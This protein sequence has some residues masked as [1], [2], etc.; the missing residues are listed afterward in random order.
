MITL[1]L[2]LSGRTFAAFD[3]LQL[4]QQGSLK[5]ETAYRI[6]GPSVFTKIKNQ[7]LLSESIKLLEKLNFKIMGRFYYDLVYPLAHNFSKNVGSDQKTEIE[8]RDTYFDYSD[9]PFDIRLGKQQIVW[10]E[11]VGLFFADVVNAKDLREFILPEFDLIRIP[12]WGID[13]EY[14]KKNFHTEFIWLPIVAFNKLG[15]RGAEFEFP[16]PVPEGTSFTTQDPPKSKNSF[17]NSEAGAR[18]SYLAHGWD[19]STFYLYSW[20]K[21]PIYYRAIASGVYNFK[22]LHK[23]LHITGLTLAK[24]I[25]K[26]VYKSEVVFTPGGY[27]SIF[28]DTDSDGIARKDFLDYLLGIDFTLFD[29]IDNTIQFMQRVI[30]DYDNHLVNENRVRNS[31]SYRINRGFWDNKL[32]AEFLVI[33]SLMEKDFLYRPKATYTFKNNWKVRVGM[34]IFN[35]KPAGVFGKF[36]KKSRV[37]SELT[38]SF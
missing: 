36:R 1:C 34:D 38:Y 14:T 6:S 23:R 31:I 5:N 20:D 12:Q 32:E 26:I 7:L 10:G 16:Y 22:P 28:D 2:Y 19:I 3:T 37:Y 13:A 15:V 27:F 9:G 30:F 29:K 24:E 18:F 33:A 35:G 4:K 21:F 17:N 11:A 8:L 25:K